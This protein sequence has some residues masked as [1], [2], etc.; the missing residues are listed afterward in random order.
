MIQS[1]IAESQ[2][3]WGVRYRNLGCHTARPARVL[4]DNLH[5]LPSKGRA[6]DVACG[7]GGNALLLARLGFEIV[8]YDISRVAVAKLNAYAQQQGLRLRAKLRDIVN[9]PPERS[10][11]EVVTVSYFL[12][13]KIT[14]VL[15]GSLRGRGLLFYQTFTREQVGTCGPENPAYRLGCNELLRLFA[16]Q[17]ILLYREEGRVGNIS[18]GFRNEAMLIGQKPAGSL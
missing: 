9:E 6:L 16:L 7:L 4:S 18:R 12:E 2:D 10:S 3:K 17:N 11:Y 5:L 14:T 15:I 13:R 1:L 8:A